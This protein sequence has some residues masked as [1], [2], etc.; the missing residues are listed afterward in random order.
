MKKFAPVHLTYKM[1]LLLGEASKLSSM[2]EAVC[3]G[4]V[5]NVFVNLEL[6]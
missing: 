6:F 1:V 5:L 3:K 4:A 2:G